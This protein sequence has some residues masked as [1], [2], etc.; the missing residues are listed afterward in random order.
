MYPYSLTNG[1]FT[2]YAFPEILRWE[3]NVQPKPHSFCTELVS[4]HCECLT[5]L[6]PDATLTAIF[7]TG[8]LVHQDQEWKGSRQD[9]LDSRRRLRCS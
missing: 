9:V 7:T 2:V 6:V 1:A 4:L 3:I 8:G 5:H